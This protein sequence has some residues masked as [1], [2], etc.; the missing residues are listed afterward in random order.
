M[1][2]TTVTEF[3]FPT[4]KLSHEDKKLIVSLSCSIFTVTPPSAATGVSSCEECPHMFRLFRKRMTKR[5]KSANYQQAPHP[6]CNQRFMARKGLEGKMHEGKRQLKKEKVQRLKEDEY[7]EF[8]DEDH[9]DILEVVKTINT[10]SFRPEMRL[11]WDCQMRQLSVKS[12][13]GHR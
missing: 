8:V 2:Q 13:K 6:K 10:T 9:I 5:C 7:V 1:T 12:A 3:L 4:R 11:L